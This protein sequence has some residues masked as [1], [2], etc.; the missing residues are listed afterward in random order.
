[1]KKKILFIGMSSNYGGLETFMM[2]VFKKLSNDSY[3]FD[4]VR[5][6]SNGEIAY[7]NEIKE[8]GGRIWKVPILDRKNKRPL[9]KYFIRKKLVK[10]FFNEH[11]N[12]DV[13]H[14]NALNI[15]GIIFWIKEAK[16]HGI[17]VVLHMHL[18]KIDNII[19]GSGFKESNLD[20]IK[21]FISKLLM[22]INLN[23]INKNKD[24]IRVAA[25]QKSGDN[26]FNGTNF[27]I[28]DNGI[29]V[30]KYKFSIENRL[31]HRSKLGISDDVNVVMTVARIS[32]QKNYP[33]IIKIFRYIKKYRPKSKLVIVG[34]GECFD[35]IV[36]MVNDFGLRNDVLFFRVK[37]RC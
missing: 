33:K 5:D 14:I 13:I 2:S 7:E 32:R 3:C 17:K 23:Y 6:F 1:M 25:S 19:P 37:K 29:E 8:N 26:F 18:D 35:E 4:F 15:N 12:Y 28:I 27:E 22:L 9:I 16:K 11:D 24:I 36:S 34:G 31:N 20:K 21:F 10:K 30:D